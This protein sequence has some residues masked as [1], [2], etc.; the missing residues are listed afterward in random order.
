MTRAA[1]LT[2]HL[3]ALPAAALLS[4]VLALMLPSHRAV[5]IEL[6]DTYFVVAHFH[7]TVVLAVSVLVASVV[8]HRYG[9]INAPIVASWAL[10]IMHVASATGQGLAR[11]GSARGMAYSYVATL[12][13]GFIAVVLGIAMSLWTGLQKRQG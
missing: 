13:G 12:V 5:D 3:V 7:A 11:H 8:A 10:L 9:A 1:V 6:H 4:A 2:A